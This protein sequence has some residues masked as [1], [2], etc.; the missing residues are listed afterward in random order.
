MRDE[1]VQGVI[2]AI[3]TPVTA[4]GEP[5]HDRFLRV[6]RY[7]LDNG[8]HG[9]NV[10]GTTGEATSF[11]AEQ[12]MA[13]M[14]ACA[15]AKLPMARLIVGTGAASTSDAV[16]LTKHAASCGFA[17]ALVI[18]PFYYKNVPDGG[19]TAYIDAI[20]EATA[21]DKLPVYLYHY[22]ALSGVPYHPDLVK[23]LRRRHGA[24]IGGLKDSSGN[25][26]Y[27]RTIAAIGGLKVFPSNE[28]TLLEAR[29]E[30]K[31]AGC[32]SATANLNAAFCA[33]AFEAGDGAAL[34]KAVSIRALFDGKPLVAGV[35]ALSAHLHR[36]NALAAMMPPFVQEA[37][38]FWRDAIARYDE[39]TAAAPA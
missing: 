37:P 32:I 11:S 5:D 15:E 24:R 34:A 14:S 29:S 22:P 38:E 6:A 21:S 3:I 27:A 30:Q 16:R 7:L 36:D 26:E 25:L 12:R 33:R 19:V 13:L 28:G 2:A 1:R 20:V 35:K 4:A 23:A 39:L 17:A 9:L 31:F 10:L 8:C 18:P